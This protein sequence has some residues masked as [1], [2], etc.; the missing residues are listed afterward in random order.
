MDIAGDYDSLKAN[1]LMCINKALV[2]ELENVEDLRPRQEYEQ[3]LQNSIK[4]QE[5]NPYLEF[6]LHER[7][8]EGSSAR[9]FRAVRNSDG[10]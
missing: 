8:G 5:N 1:P 3:A 7:I 6:Q 4:I 2:R 9:I 10:K